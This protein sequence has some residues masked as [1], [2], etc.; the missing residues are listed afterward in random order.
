MRVQMTPPSIWGLAENG[1]D[2]H[3]IRAK[4]R[5]RKVMPVGPTGRMATS[6]VNHPGMKPLGSPIKRT[7]A[8]VPKVWM[9]EQTILVGKYL[10]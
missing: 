8:E 5:A 9:T 3:V 6:P 7:A 4:G 2:P 10:R 1:A